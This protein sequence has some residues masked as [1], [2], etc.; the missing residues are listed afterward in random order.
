MDDRQ[1][2][3]AGCVKAAV[4]GDHAQVLYKLGSN[5]TSNNLLTK[6]EAYLTGSHAGSCDQ[7]VII[8]DT[9]ALVTCLHHAACR[10]HANVVLV[11]MKY[12]SAP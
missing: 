4:R 3:N 8:P 11:L 2:V 5:F 1:T 12:R 10:G 7:L 6:V 9:C